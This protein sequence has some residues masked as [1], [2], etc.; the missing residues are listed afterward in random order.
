[1]VDDALVAH[2]GAGRGARLGAGIAVEP[3]AQA[4]PHAGG[5]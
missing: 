3:L 5:S 2:P 4:Q 1:L